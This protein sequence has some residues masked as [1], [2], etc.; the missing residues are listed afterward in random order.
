MTAR[1]NP[2]FDLLFFD[3]GSRSYCICV[4][5]QISSSR[6]PEAGGQCS[7]AADQREHKGR[8]FRRIIAAGLRAHQAASVNQKVTTLTHSSRWKGQMSAILPP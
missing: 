4:K 2:V 7:G 5:L 1:L 8:V 6:F 3:P